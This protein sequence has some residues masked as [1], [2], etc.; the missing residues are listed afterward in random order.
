MIWFLFSLTPFWSFCLV[1]LPFSQLLFYFSAAI[2]LVVVVYEVFL[3]IYDITPGKYQNLIVSSSFFRFSV[4]VGRGV[5]GIWELRYYNVRVRNGLRLSA[6]E[7]KQITF[8]NALL[9][10][11]VLNVSL[12]IL[13]LLHLVLE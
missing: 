7:R 13:I 8:E 10:A 3:F 12:S 1:F 2:C 11:F 6:A 5:C 9:F 4:F